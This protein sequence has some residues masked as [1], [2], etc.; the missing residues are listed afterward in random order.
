MGFDSYHWQEFPLSD[1]QLAECR[2]KLASGRGGPEDFLALL[3]SGDPVAVGV[4]FDQYKQAEALTRFGGSHPYG[5]YDGAVRETARRVLAEP[6]YPARE[7]G[8]DE[9]GLN[10]ASALLALAHLATADDGDRIAALVRTR[11]S[12]AVMNAAGQAATCALLASGKPSGDLV[13]ALSTVLLDESGRTRDRLDALGPFRY[14][15]DEW[16]GDILARAARTSDERVQAEVVAILVSHFLATRRDVIEEVA[17]SWMPNPSRIQERVL[18]AL[19]A[20]ERD[21]HGD[22]ESPSR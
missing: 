15:R 20:A 9:P 3:R 7:E 6:P 11:P 13:E 18:R 17:A 8:E 1:P 14:V 5:E 21:P 16:V 2:E 19:A 10:H 4:A 22:Q 12:P